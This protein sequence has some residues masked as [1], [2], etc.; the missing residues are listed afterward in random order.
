MEIRDHKTKISDKKTFDA[1]NPECIY[2]IVED[3][4]RYNRQYR[5]CLGADDKHF[6]PCFDKYDDKLA[7]MSHTR[8]LVVHLC[9][10]CPQHLTGSTVECI[11]IV[12]IVNNKCIV[13][14]NMLGLSAKYV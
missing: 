14:R 1:H 5:D 12:C 9:M 2:N 6:P 11:R 13:L 4:D 10:I 7:F 3:R 8:Q